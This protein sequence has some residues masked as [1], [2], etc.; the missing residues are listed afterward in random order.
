[1]T[2]WV[3]GLAAL[4][5]GG[6]AQAQVYGA[7]GAGGG[8]GAGGQNP[9]AGLNGAFAPN[10]Y[11]RTQQPLS[12]YLNLLNGGNP[13][14]NYFYGAR[15]GLNP[16]VSGLGGGFGGT[17]SAVGPPGFGNRY[18]L[19][20]PTDFDELPSQPLEAN[21]RLSILPTAAHP[22]TFGNGPGLGGGFR[23]AGR[24]GFGAQQPAGRGGSSTTPPRR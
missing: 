8:T 1:M 10:V 18:Y 4:A 19:Q 7:P 17:G 2:R 22:V 23:A 21:R 3:F 5:L 11:N 6:A 14:V 24:T 9:A 15:P 13:A 20:P 16:A 12:P